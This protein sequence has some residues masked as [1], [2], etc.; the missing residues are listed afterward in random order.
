[1]R[2]KEIID[3]LEDYAGGIKAISKSEL[4]DMYREIYNNDNLKTF[5]NLVAYLKN[6]QTITAFSRDKFLVLNKRHYSYTPSDEVKMIDEIISTAYPDFKYIVWETSLINEFA[7]HMAMTNYIIVEVEKNADVFI[8]HALKDKLKGYSI[9]TEGLFNKSRDMIFN[10]EK[11]IIIKGLHSKAPLK[12]EDNQNKY[13][14]YIEKLIVDL[15]KDEL[16][17]QF[18]G[19]EFEYIYENI[20]E[21]YSIDY[22]KLLNYAKVRGV[23]D[24]LVEILGRL[25]KKV[26]NMEA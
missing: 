4:Y 19:S 24:G 11:V 1:M 22:L 9:Y 16:Y 15:Y 3:R 10:D 20:I 26:N 18:Q 25:D 5:N 12:K 2:Y 13:S 14:L 23:Y 17:T 21:R 8:I 6:R 7:H